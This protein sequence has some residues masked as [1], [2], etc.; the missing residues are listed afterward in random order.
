MVA[1]RCHHAIFR[2]FVKTHAD[3]ALFN[4]KIRLAAPGKSR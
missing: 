2:V 3:I 1:E 4:S